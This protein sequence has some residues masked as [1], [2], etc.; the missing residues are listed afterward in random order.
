MGQ[1]PPDA[2]DNFYYHFYD[3][4]HTK[5]VYYVSQCKC[6][7]FSIR[8]ITSLVCVLCMYVQY[9]SKSWFDS[10]REIPGC[11]P[12]AWN[13]D[14]KKIMP[15]SWHSI[16]SLTHSPSPPPPPPPPPCLSYMY[17]TCSLPWVPCFLYS[18][19]HRDDLHRYRPSQEQSVMPLLYRHSAHPPHWVKKKM[20]VKNHQT[21]LKTCTE[22]IYVHMQDLIECAREHATLI[23]QNKTAKS[24]HDRND[25]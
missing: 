12:S 23:L 24:K 10:G 7:H 15:E 11:P 9:Q 16:F 14:N 8:L 19:S 22:Y 3:S 17:L 18:V 21:K 2:K 25:F 1:S 5:S 4:Q 20:N 13:R 6:V